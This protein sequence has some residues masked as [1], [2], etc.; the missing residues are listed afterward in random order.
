MTSRR[1]R[2]AGLDPGIHTPQRAEAEGIAGSSPT[3][4]Y[5]G[6]SGRLAET[7]SAPGGAQAVLVFPQS[8]KAVCGGL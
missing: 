6:V 3:M 4:M 7:L 1:G 8:E 5:L 2:H